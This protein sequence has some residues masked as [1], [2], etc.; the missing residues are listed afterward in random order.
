MN[1]KMILR[2]DL[3]DKIVQEYPHLKAIANNIN[4]TDGS[5]SLSLQKTLAQ[6]ASTVILKSLTASEVMEINQAANAKIK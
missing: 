2:Q 5:R 1:D 6:T 3:I 4:E